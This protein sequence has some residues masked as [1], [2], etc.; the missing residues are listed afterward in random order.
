MIGEDEVELAEQ[1]QEIE[2]EALPVVVEVDAAAE[3]DRTPREFEE[4]A[5]NAEIAANDGEKQGVDFLS[6]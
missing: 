1:T 4:E 2:A 3:E 5:D 6:F